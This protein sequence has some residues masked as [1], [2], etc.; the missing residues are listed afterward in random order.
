M[1]DDVWPDGLEPIVDYVKSKGMEFGLWFEPEMVN[2]NSD[3]FRSR[4]QWTL[5]V[6]QRAPLESR[7]Q[8][9][10]DLGRPEVVDYLFGQMSA[11]LSTYRIDFVKWDHNRPLADAGSGLRSGAPGV[12]PATVGFC[13]LLDRLRAEHPSVQW[14]S[15]ASGG[16]R[17]DLGVIERADRF[18][19]SDC[20]DALS[21]Q[22]IQRWTSQL[23][24]FEYLG[25]HVAAPINHQT[26]R[27]LSLDFRC[28]TAFFGS[29]GVEWDLTQASEEERNRL[30]E[31]IHAFKRYRALLHSGQAFRND[32]PDE[33]AYLYGVVSADGTE[34]I[35]AHAQLDETVRDMVPWTVPGLE[36]RRRYLVRQVMP[37]LRAGNGEVWSWRGDGITLSGETLATVGLS[38]PR[39][40]PQTCMIAHVVEWSSTLPRA[41]RSSSTDLRAVVLLSTSTRSPWRAMALRIRRRRS[42]RRYKSKLV[43]SCS[44]LQR[45]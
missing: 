7:N 15:C 5:S 18:W 13:Q 38:I 4:P 2:P 35:T 39:R 23:V 6:G 9:V 42:G 16:G 43:N 32:V 34:A 40:A 30:A 12:H 14:K 37:T 19:T 22:R 31:W 45:H 36:P 25:A 20:T 26:G 33:S 10:L 29:F 21:R 28:A 17:I 24:P 1:S 8:L 27:R 11:V 44:R 3:L 41:A